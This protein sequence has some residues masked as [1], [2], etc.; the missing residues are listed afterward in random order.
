[1]SLNILLRNSC[2]ALDGILFASSRHCHFR[3]TV[4]DNVVC[5]QT[6]AIWVSA[7]GNICAL[8]Y[9]RPTLSCTAT[10]VLD[11]KICQSA[12]LFCRIFIQS[13]PCNLSQDTQLTHNYSI[14][15]LSYIFLYICL[16]FSVFYFSFC[17]LS[18]LSLFQE[19]F[20][21]ID[22]KRFYLQTIF[23]IFVFYSFHYEFVSFFQRLRIILYCCSRYLTLESV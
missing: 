6:M 10:C 21:Q 5:F 11:F 16:V 20:C 19:I 17:S 8:S 22:W 18:L 1:M 7:F 9:H 2:F 3:S 13:V 23:Q 4:F 15:M 14:S 12:Q